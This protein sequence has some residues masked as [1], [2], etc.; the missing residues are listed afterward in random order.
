MNQSTSQSKGYRGQWLFGILRILMG[1]LF[2][3]AFID[4]VFGLGFSTKSD[5]S[6]LDGVSPTAGFL[7][8][9]ATG[10][11]A[12]MYH[13][14]ANSDIVAWLFMLGLLG[15]GLA[16]ILGI[17]VKIAGYSGALL[18]LLMWSALLPTETNPFLDEHIIYLF[19][20]LIFTR[21]PVGDYLGL[22]KYW[23]QTGLVKKY[24]ILK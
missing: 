23:E 11:F 21:I 22:G 13:S 3:W 10:P 8:K 20:F 15:I 24:S 12:S 5:K 1:F 7:G 6:W 16:L 9:A 18:M 2:F 17:G 14:M 19:L 4:K